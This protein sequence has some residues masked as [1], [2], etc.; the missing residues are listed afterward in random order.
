M[1]KF[2][3]AIAL[4]IA[5]AAAL[6]SCST[7][8][9][10]ENRSS[11]PLAEFYSSATGEV[12]AFDSIEVSGIGAPADSILSPAGS[13]ISQ[14]YMPM[15]STREQT[16]WRFAYRWK[17]LDYPELYDT[18][19]IDY[20]ST[21]Y[22]ASDECGVIYRYHIDKLETTRHLI[23]DVEITDSLI[24][25]IDKVYLKIYFRTI[26]DDTE[27]EENADEAG[28]EVAEP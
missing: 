9:C 14:L 15:R 26:E 19:T 16:Q 6:S 2:L 11:I 18:L 22:F 4:T 7:S 25:N 24:T 1:G 28:E 13:A 10:L 3:I 17:A 5:A 8:G 12:A 20:T 21:P 23:E 27:T